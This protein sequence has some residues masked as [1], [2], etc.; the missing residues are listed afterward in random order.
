MEELKRLRKTRGL[1]Q[2]K[3]AALADLDPSTVSQIE[4]GARRAN[5]RTLERLA[6]ALGA[7][8]ADL[9]PKA[10]SPLP[11]EEREE[12]H[13][14]GGPSLEQIRA[15]LEE[16]VGSAWIA[17]PTEEWENWWRFVPMEEATRRYR[18][19]RAEYRL[20][21]DEW[22]ATHAKEGGT[23]TLVPRGGRWGDVFY[24]LFA[25]HFGAPFFA[26]Q[27]GESERDFKKRQLK[28]R[29]AA[30]FYEELREVTQEALRATTE[31]ANG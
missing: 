9:F 22:N 11:L 5:T 19:I 21:A 26:P 30:S 31:G 29:A 8:V 27:K 12:Q 3:L 24:E 7:E 4:T 10:Q 18:Q 1:S 15:F 23:P 20:I 13:V 14:G 28:N 2:A 17:L 25:R 16:Q 6:A